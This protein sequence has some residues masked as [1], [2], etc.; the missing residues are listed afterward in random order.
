MDN[1]RAL[2]DT[3]KTI[4]TGKAEASGVLPRRYAVDGQMEPATGFPWNNR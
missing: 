1:V 3:L 4:E 2:A